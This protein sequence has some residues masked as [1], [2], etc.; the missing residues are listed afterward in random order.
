MLAKRTK[1]PLYAMY[2]AGILRV[3]QKVKLLKES[4]QKRAKVASISKYG[5]MIYK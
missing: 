5:N 1:A 4:L 2:G 3:P